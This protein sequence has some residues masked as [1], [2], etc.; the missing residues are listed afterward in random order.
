MA[1]IQQ[2]GDLCDVEFYAKKTA[3]AALQTLTLVGAFSSHSTYEADM[4]KH[5]A[6]LAEALGYD[7]SKRDTQR[8]DDDALQPVFGGADYGKKPASHAIEQRLR[9]A[10]S[11]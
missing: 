11:L 10:G 2:F 9:E 8:R 1:T 7:I 5:F 4:H 3:D 6:K